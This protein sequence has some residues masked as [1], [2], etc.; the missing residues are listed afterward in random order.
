MMVLQLLLLLLQRCLA[1]CISLS[2][3]I[4]RGRLN[5]I[6]HFVSTHQDVSKTSDLRGK[7]TENRKQKKK[8]EKAEKVEKAATVCIINYDLRCSRAWKLLF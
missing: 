5:Q 6:F 4:V 2:L 7:L 1:N 8:A 3:L